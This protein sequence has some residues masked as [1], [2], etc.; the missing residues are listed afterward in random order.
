MNKQKYR[1]AGRRGFEAH[2]VLLHLIGKYRDGIANTCVR[3]KIRE[4]V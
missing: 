1:T 3:N 2:F 4:F